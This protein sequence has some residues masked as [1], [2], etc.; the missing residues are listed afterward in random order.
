MQ[1]NLP[2]QQEQ[3]LERFQPS[4]HQ[5]MPPPQAQLQPGVHKSMEEPLL[6]NQLPQDQQLRL[7]LA[8]LT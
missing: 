8:A 2:V 7:Q 1:Q 4:K 5:P 6:S 3:Q